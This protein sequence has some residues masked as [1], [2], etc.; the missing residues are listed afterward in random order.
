VAAR[1]GEGGV[2]KACVAA[3]R[4]G[5]GGAV[6]WRDGGELDQSRGQRDRRSRLKIGRT[7]EQE[8]QTTLTFLISST[9]Y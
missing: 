5:I 6:P 4:L 9:D 3:R 8:R 1:R 2:G 7:A